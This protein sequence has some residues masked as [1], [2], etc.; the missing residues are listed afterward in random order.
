MV[1]IP[2]QFWCEF[3][4]FCPPVM[5]KAGRTNDHE[6][7]TGFRLAGGFGSEVGEKADGLQCLTETHVIRQ[8]GTRIDF[9]E[10]ADPFKSLL[11]VR[12]QLGLD[13]IG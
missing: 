11:L 4:Q 10:Q 2:P 7:P 9:G 6:A 8:A 13:H 5:H 12:S 1:D 3:F